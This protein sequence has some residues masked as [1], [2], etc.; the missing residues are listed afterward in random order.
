MNHSCYP[1]GYRLALC[2]QY[3]CTNSLYIYIQAGPTHLVSTYI[4]PI[5]IQAGPTHSGWLCIFG[6]QAWASLV[7]QTVKKKKQNCLQCRRP[8]F[9]PWI[10]KTH[11]E[12][13]MATHSSI[14]AWKTPWIE[15]PGRLQ[16]TGSQRV[17]HD[18]VT[19]T[20]GEFRVKKT[21]VHSK[22]DTI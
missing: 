9:D 7:A 3:L 20:F 19:N 2:I 13:G 8:G 21:I 18:R 1:M 11:L 6:R 4:Q 10:G 22:H 5:Y 17:G 12:K 16:S 15:E 14:L